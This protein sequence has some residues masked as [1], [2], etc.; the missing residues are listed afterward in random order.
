[1][2]LFA[3]RGPFLQKVDYFLQKV[4]EKKRLEPNSAHKHD[5]VW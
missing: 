1:V 2:D 5:F 4:E 3:K